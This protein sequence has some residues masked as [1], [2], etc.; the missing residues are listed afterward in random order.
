MI[1]E[2]MTMNVRVLCRLTKP[3]KLLP[4]VAAVAAAALRGK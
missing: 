4:A 1:V 3:V 2:T